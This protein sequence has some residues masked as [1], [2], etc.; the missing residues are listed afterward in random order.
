MTFIPFKVHSVTLSF[1]KYWLCSSSVSG[2]GL[3]L[4]A[5]H[6]ALVN[7]TCV[8]PPYSPL[9]SPTL[10]SITQNDTDTH[11][12]VSFGSII[13]LN[14]WKSPLAVKK[15]ASEVKS[16]G[17]RILVTM[18]RGFSPRFYVPPPLKLCEHFY[19]AFCTPSFFLMPGTFLIS[20]LLTHC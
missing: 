14:D 13:S 7:R 15:D 1:H 4:E 5:G 8:D 16:R 9:S 20:Q 10:G 19:F 3:I 2:P 17:A 11:L 12:H 6:T 18:A